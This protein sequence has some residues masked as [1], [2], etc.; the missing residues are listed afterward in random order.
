MK[1]ARPRR[2]RYRAAQKVRVQKIRS[3]GKSGGR[4]QYKAPVKP[5]GA[6]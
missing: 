4:V 3:T 2:F 5:K 1:A 6:K